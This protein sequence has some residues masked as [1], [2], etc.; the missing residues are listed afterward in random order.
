MKKFLE[1]ILTKIGEYGE[2]IGVGSK[3]QNF[4]HNQKLL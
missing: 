1:M 4:S 3:F 2:K